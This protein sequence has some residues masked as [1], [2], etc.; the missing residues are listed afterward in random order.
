MQAQFQEK[1]DNVD[2]KIL[3]IA[4][5][6][7]VSFIITELNNTILLSLV[8]CD[9]TKRKSPHLQQKR[10]GLVRIRIRVFERNHLRRVDGCHNY[11]HLA[12]TL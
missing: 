1:V 6:Q 10:R 4:A 5:T 2:K 8:I 12:T 3:E 9:C 11:S 7:E